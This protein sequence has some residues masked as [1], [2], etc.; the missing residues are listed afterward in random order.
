MDSHNLMTKPNPKTNPMA[1]L[2][3]PK[4]L[5]NCSDYILTYIDATII[6]SASCHRLAGW[7]WLGASSCTPG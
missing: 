5:S 4:P 7:H 3:L 1:N 6:L 2:D